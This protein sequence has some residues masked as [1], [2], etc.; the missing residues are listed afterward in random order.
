MDKLSS[1]IRSTKIHM[2]NVK[3]A[4]LALLTTERA[5]KLDLLIHLITNLKQSLVISGPKG[6]GK[7][8]LLEEL[9]NCG[10]DGLPVLSLPASSNLN[11]ESFQSQLIQLILSNLNYQIENPDLSVI[12][13]LFEKKNHKVVVVID[14]AGQLVPGLINTLIQYASEYKCLRVIFAL[15]TDEIQQK[16][17]SDQSIEGCHF[18]ELPPLTKQQSRD[19]LQK[20]SA[21]PDTALSLNDVNGSLIDHI[22]NE[23]NGVPGAIMSEISEN[24]NGT[25]LGFKRYKWLGIALAYVVVMTL[26]GF[27]IFNESE[28]RKEDGEYNSYLDI[29]EAEDLPIAAPYGQPQVKIDNET[30]VGQGK[31]DFYQEQEKD[32]IQDV[33]EDFKIIEDKKTNIVKEIKPIE[34]A[35]KAETIAKIDLVENKKLVAE[36]LAKKTDKKI[37]VEVISQQKEQII[38]KSKEIEIIKDDMTTENIFKFSEDGV[39]DKKDLLSTRSM[40]ESEAKPDKDKAVTDELAEKIMTAKQGTKNSEKALKKAINNKKFTVIPARKVVEEKA[41]ESHISKD[42]TVKVAEILA[43]KKIIDNK[44]IKVS[45]KALKNTSNNSEDK[46]VEE[47]A[48]KKSVVSKK[49]D[50]QWILSQPEAYY[51]MQ[52]IVL[53]NRDAVTGFFQD[54][55]T[56]LGDLKFFQKKRKDG[57]QFVVIYGAFKDAEMASKQMKS[58]PPRFKK[59]WVRSFGGLQEMI[60]N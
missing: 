42:K 3:S 60:N 50:R 51:T 38:E 39:S 7:T 59:A 15:T 44:E 17:S 32:N 37:A 43:E 58:L 6:I 55:P 4:E 33:T 1:I 46:A 40:I 9:K 18:I 30:E 45:E 48:I 11:S 21:R 52:L 2:P 22:Y 29:T 26:S 25:G 23:T 28:E 12:L 56:L 13:S 41:I 53:S 57:V 36:L 34:I 24:N 35:E 16:I 54:Y 19:F 27:F 8:T 20:I 47:K 31:D 10:K 14:D 5:Q 49:S